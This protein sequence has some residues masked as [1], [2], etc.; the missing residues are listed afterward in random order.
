LVSM[1]IERWRA[2][3]MARKSGFDYENREPNPVYVGGWSA[4]S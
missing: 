1:V 4:L 3:T 2:S